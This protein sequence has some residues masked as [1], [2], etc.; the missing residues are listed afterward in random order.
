VRAS[1]WHG[2]DPDE[3]GRISLSHAIWWIA[4]QAGTNPVALDDQSRWERAYATL[5]GYIVDGK[6]PIFATYPRP[7]ERMPPEHFAGM[8][9]RFLLGGIPMR[10]RHLGAHILCAIGT[11]HPWGDQWFG[12]SG[13]KAKWQRLMIP[14]AELIEWVRVGRLAVRAKAEPARRAPKPKAMPKTG[15]RKRIM[16][17]M[18]ADLRQKHLTADDLH[19]MP[20]SELIATYGRDEGAGRTS[21]REARAAA[22]S[23]FEGD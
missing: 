22:L 19:R 8:P 1:I 10:G 9:V 16:Q 4:S 23:E 12:H 13:G 11:E 20:E 5:V 2:N 14:S 6:V 18:L 3:H 21:V 17:K 7:V 15:K